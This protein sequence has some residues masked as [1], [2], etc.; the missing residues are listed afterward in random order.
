MP[1]RVGENRRDGRPIWKAVV[2]VT[3]NLELVVFE[4]NAL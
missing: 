3:R 4:Y 2:D 1:R